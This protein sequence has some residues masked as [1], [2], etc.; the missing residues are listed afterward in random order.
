MSPKELR[1]GAKDLLE[2]LS[3]HKLKLVWFLIAAGVVSGILAEPPE[4]TFDAFKL[5]NAT[6][7]EPDKQPRQQHE[8]LLFVRQVFS[9]GE[10]KA[11]FAQPKRPKEP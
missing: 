7:Y 11:A 6:I 2:F 9:W 3:T 5:I 8:V 10:G 4:T 1:T